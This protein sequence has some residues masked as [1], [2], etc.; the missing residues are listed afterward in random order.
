MKRAKVLKMA[1][2]ITTA[3]REQQYGDPEDNFTAIANMW[4]GYLEC[5]V[6][7]ADVA[8]MMILLKVARIASGQTVADN[9]IDIAGYAACGG[10]IQTKKQEAGVVDPAEMDWNV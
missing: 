4:S 6:T 8:A 10:E 1:G 3:D 2:Q 9:W 7:P 5:P